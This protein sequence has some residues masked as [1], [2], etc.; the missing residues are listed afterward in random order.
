MDNGW[1][2]YAKDIGRTLAKTHLNNSHRA[3]IDAILDKT[4]GWIDLKSPN[5]KPWK[6][7]KTKET[8]SYKF[9]SDFT[10]ME[11]SNLSKNI[12]D[13]I[14]WK[15][16][17]RIKGGRYFQYSLNVNT[18]E[19][20]Q[21][22]FRS[23]YQKEL[24]HANNPIEDYLDNEPK[25]I[26]TDNLRLLKDITKTDVKANKDKGCMD[27]N[28]LIRNNY[29]NKGEKELKYTM[30]SFEEEKKIFNFWN[31]QNIN[32]YEVFERFK[33]IIKKVLNIYSSEVVINA[34]KNY[35]F[36]LKNEEYYY[37]YIFS[38][39]NFLEPKNIDKFRDLEIA[40]NNYKRK[41]VN[42]D[43]KEEE[44]YNILPYKG[45]ENEKNGIEKSEEESNAE[46]KKI[47][48]KAG[49]LA[50]QFKREIRK[51]K[52]SWLHENKA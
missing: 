7:R 37:D 3:I 16:I 29:I 21:K 1:F 26:E 43:F 9:F 25:V 46:R 13:L 5:K 50:R 40:K 12:N 39:Y 41:K 11:K 52:M 27:S 15:I 23:K 4:Y 2:F 35:A 20:C 14:N 44:E 33:E 19:W 24:M 6:R 10:G 17:K 49:E 38:L 31:D 47:G 32:N 34:I 8:I 42:G 45:K 28:K 30:G 51:K 36:I 18:R 48:D 22:V